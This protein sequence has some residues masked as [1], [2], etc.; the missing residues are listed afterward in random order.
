MV[1]KDNKWQLVKRKEQIDDLYEYNEVVL[2]TWYKEKKEKMPEMVK[3][4]N[5]I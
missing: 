2:E 1:Y 5:A 3:S 4:F